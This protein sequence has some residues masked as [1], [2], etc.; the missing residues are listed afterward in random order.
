MAVAVSFSDVDVT[1]R[2]TNVFKQAL[3]VLILLSQITELFFKVQYR[4]SHLIHFRNL[5]LKLGVDILVIHDDFNCSC[6]LKFDK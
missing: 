6:F 1:L 4:L 5:V 3:F 2:T